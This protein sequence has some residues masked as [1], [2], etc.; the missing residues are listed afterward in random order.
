MLLVFH[1]LNL[2]Y[3]SQ[4]CIAGLDEV[5]YL[6]TSANRREKNKSAGR[7]DLEWFTR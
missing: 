3:F 2:V 5:G 7:V 1:T 6:W 4:I